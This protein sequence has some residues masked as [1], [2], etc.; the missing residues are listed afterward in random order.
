MIDDNAFAEIQRHTEGLRTC[1]NIRRNSEPK[2]KTTDEVFEYFDYLLTLHESL[3]HM[4]FNQWGE[5][6][7]NNILK[8]TEK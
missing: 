8:N 6:L 3:K 5:A 2:F 7:T 4:E 1:A